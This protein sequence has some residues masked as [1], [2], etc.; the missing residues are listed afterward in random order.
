MPFTVKLTVSP[1]ASSPVTAP[2]TATVPPASAALITSSAVIESTV[3]LPSPIMSTLWVESAVAVMLFP[4][5]S[6]PV[7]VTVKLVSATRSL[8]ATSAP[9]VPSAET[10]VL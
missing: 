1:S 6:V 10:V 2:V 4:A 8:P 7:A 5:S 3:T 9:H